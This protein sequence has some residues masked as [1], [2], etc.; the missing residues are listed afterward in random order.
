MTRWLYH[1]QQVISITDSRLDAW[2][3]PCVIQWEGER[4]GVHRGLLSK[5]M[6]WMLHISLPLIPHWQDYTHVAIPCCK[7]GKKCSF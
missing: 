3:L 7:T 6:T 4:R 2:R 5:F 1:L